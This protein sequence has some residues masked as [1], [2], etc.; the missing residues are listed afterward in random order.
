MNDNVQYISPQGLKKL[1]EELNYRK[2]DLRKEI[3]EKISTAKEMGDLSENFEYQEAKE[4]Q[5]TNEAKIIELENLLRNSIVVDSQTGGDKIGIGC[6]FK[7]L[8][9]ESEE[10]VFEIVGASESDPLNG[11]ISNE[12]PLGQKF[13]GLAKD[14]IVEFNSPMGITR[15]KILEI[16]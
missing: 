4:Q 5:A 15:Y 13:L 8:I 1:Q 14:D 2:N 11:K 16:L 12:S 3:A 6:K 10:K 7:V 9:N